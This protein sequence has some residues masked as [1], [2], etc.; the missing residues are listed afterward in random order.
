MQTFLA[1]PNFKQ[2]AA[3]LDNSRLGNQCYRECKTLLNGGWQY[4]PASKMWRGYEGALCLYALALVDE[5]EKR[6]RWKPEVIERWRNY[7]TEQLEGKGTDMPP[8]IGNEQF[9]AAHRSNL[10]RKDPDYYSQF[11][12]TESSDLEYV[13]PV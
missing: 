3:V 11:G 6:G 2:S 12:W 8:W 5:M 9:H 7:Y 1:Y 10:L 13:W 4:H